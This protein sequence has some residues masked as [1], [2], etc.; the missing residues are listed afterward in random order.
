MQLTNKN[1]NFN[2]KNPLL[3]ECLRNIA[4]PKEVFFAVTQHNHIPGKWS[5]TEQKQ[6]RRILFRKYS[7]RKGKN[8]V[9][10]LQRDFVQKFILSVKNH[11]F[12]YFAHKMEYFHFDWFQSPRPEK[13]KYTTFCKN[14]LQVKQ[15]GS[16][17]CLS[18]TSTWMMGTV[19]ETST[20]FQADNFKSTT[21]WRKKTFSHFYGIS[22]ASLNSIN[23]FFLCIWHLNVMHSIISIASIFLIIIWRFLHSS[24]ALNNN[25]QFPT[26]YKWRKQWLTAFS[27]LSEHF[28]FV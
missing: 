5:Y 18:A 15:V 4:Q 9:F 7:T 17:G 14:I 28:H 10:R 27:V 13:K 25:I 20:E 21:A 12:T 22:L 2:E 16:S 11:H 8:E 24:L 3:K 1:W 6:T 19:S 26:A 23:E